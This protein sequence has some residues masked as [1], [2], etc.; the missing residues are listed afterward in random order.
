MKEF[1]R[2]KVL[3]TGGLGFIGSNL[4]R[5]LVMHGAEVTLADSLIP[6]YGGNKHNI[7]DIRGQVTVNVCDV[8]DRFAFEYL[9]QGQD[10]LFNLAGQTS[11][12]DS[13]TDPQAD[14]D[15]NASAE[16]SI[17]EACRRTNSGVRL[18]FASTR[19]L[20]GRPVYLP[21]DENHPIR[22]VDVN[23]INKL[24]GEGYHLLYSS[25]YGIRSSVLRLTNTYGP[26]MRGKEHRKTFV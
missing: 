22:P 26:G 2:K 11:H 3:I 1:Q 10:F 19:Q 4:A 18:V 16:L 21:V 12:I 14:L 13:M 25:V 24:A 15:I 8:R 6:Q 9:V 7:A 5:R 23:G 20:Y 17:L